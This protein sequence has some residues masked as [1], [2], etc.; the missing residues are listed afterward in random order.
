VIEATSPIFS[1]WKL[2]SNS[3]AFAVNINPVRNLV[4]GTAEIATATTNSR[5]SGCGA[6]LHQVD[7]IPASAS[8]AAKACPDRALSEPICLRRAGWFRSLCS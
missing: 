8:M 5:F 6:A 3:F 1:H 4:I 7:F 2:R